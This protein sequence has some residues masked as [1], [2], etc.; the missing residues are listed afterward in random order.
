MELKSSGGGVSI[1][2]GAAKVLRWPVGA[3]EYAAPT[4]AYRGGLEARRRGT[5]A[6]QR[7]RSPKR[8]SLVFKLSRSSFGH[9][10]SGTPGAAE[11][12]GRSS[13]EDPGC[14]P[15]EQRAPR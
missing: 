3:T 12:G 13:C 4:Q 5:R 11:L 6:G 7:Q 8:P 2:R 1:A 10:P 15:D 14:P 9:G